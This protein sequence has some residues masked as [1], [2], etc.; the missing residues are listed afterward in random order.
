MNAFKVEL[1]QRVLV[2]ALGTL[3]EGTGPGDGGLV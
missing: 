2:R 3:A 1:A